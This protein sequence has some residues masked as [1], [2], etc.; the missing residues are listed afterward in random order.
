MKLIY[1]EP[2][3]FCLDSI[4]AFTQLQT[5]ASKTAIWL[6][7]ACGP[8]EYYV[9]NFNIDLVTDQIFKEIEEEGFDE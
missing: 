8:D 7:G 3:W 9:S 2:F 1:L 5:D 4:V 6:K